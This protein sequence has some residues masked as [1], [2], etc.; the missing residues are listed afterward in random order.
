MRRRT[1]VGALAVLGW[2]VLAGLAPIAAGA[3]DGTVRITATID[4]RDVANAG[5]GDP[6]VIDPDH[7]QNVVVR[8]AN[9][10]AEPVSVRSVRMEARALGLLVVSLESRVDRTIQPGSADELRFP[11][12][13]S[14]VRGR[15]VGLVA[16][17]LTALDGDGRAL[18]D[19]G[20][21]A[22]ARGSIWSVEG[23]IG[24]AAVAFTLASVF[25]GLVDV[26][27]DRQPRTR[28]ARAAR[29]AVPGVTFG[30]SV[31]FL[32]ALTRLSAPRP[33]LGVLLVVA[34]GLVGFVAGWSSPA[35]AVDDVIDLVAL[36]R[37]T[38]I[39]LTAEADAERGLAPS[40]AAA[41]VSAGATVATAPV[42]STMATPPRPTAGAGPSTNG[43][44]GDHAS[45]PGPA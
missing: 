42:P 14:G 29:F 5:D 39:D 20:F 37:P 3:A 34:G 27:R 6:I 30:L 15:A 45:G 38:E 16:T 40:P 22:D 32:L 31:A 9:E 11:L 1:R 36:E 25:V 23:V 2:V 41:P 26:A 35:P 19:T 8:V 33:A 12:D 10:G 28:W 4:G 44:G 13:T 17:T 7:V 24:M 18:A 21:V 43:R